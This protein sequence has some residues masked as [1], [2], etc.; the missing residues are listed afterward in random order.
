MKYIQL[1]ERERYQLEALMQTC[2]IQKMIAEAL[3]KK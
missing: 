3:G 1:T 2:S